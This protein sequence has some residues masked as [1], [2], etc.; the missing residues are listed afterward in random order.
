MYLVF[1][2]SD[3]LNYFY[4]LNSQ[5]CTTP[6][7][8]PSSTFFFL[9]SSVFST[10]CSASPPKWPPE[11]SGSLRKKLIPWNSWFCHFSQ[12]HHHSLRRKPVELSWM[13][14]LFSSSSDRHTLP[15]YHQC[16]LQ[17]FL[18]SHFHCQPSYLRLLI[19]SFL[20]F[21]FT[22]MTRTCLSIFRVSSVSIREAESLW[23]LWGRGYY[24]LTVVGGAGTEALC[25]VACVWVF[26]SCLNSTVQSDRSQQG[27]SVPNQ[28]RGVKSVWMGHWLCSFFCLNFPFLNL[29]KSQ[30]LMFS[31]FLWIEWGNRHGG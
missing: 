19:N 27:S 4:Q 20:P 21:F 24:A 1:S 6:G 31:I 30:C 3:Y 7:S 16:L 8:I 12:W 28:E 23:V 17:L 5:L 13:H 2:S 25:P 10:T 9:E 22:S 18:F 14:H 15:I 11:I 29:L 26:L